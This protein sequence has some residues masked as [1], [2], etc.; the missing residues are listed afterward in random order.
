MREQF[1]EDP[2]YEAYIN[3]LGEMVNNPIKRIK[4]D[5]TDYEKAFNERE[6]IYHSFMRE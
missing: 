3:T 2:D 6:R 5:F 1:D 4:E